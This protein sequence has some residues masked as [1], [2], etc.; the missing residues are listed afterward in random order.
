MTPEQRYKTRQTKPR[1]RH[2]AKNS[3]RL[4]QAMREHQAGNLAEADRLYGSVLKKNPDDA[5]ALNLRGIL[6]AQ[7][8]RPA[9]GIDYISR[10]LRIDD[11][12]PFYHYNLALVYQA[13][14]NREAAIAS[15]R[16]ALSL[17]SDYVD[18]LVNLGNLLFNKGENAEA[19]ACY[20]KATRLAPGNAMAHNNLGAALL[21]Q[22]T[23]NEAAIC[24]REALRL[25]P[26]YA[27]AHNGLGATFLGLELY[28]E[29]EVSLKAALRHD[30]G[31][32]RAHNNLGMTYACKG[33]FEDAIASFRAA[34][35]FNPA[36][37]E[38]HLNL[39]RIN[40][41]LD[42]LDAAEASYREA[43]RL[44]P[45]D[46]KARLCLGK[47][48]EE[49]EDFDTALKVF[50]EIL[51]KNPNH[52]LALTG[53]ASVL[54]RAGR[55]A[56]ANAI[57]RG[58]VDAGTLPPEAA[59]I[60]AGLADTLSGASKSETSRSEVA[61]RLENA[62]EGSFLNSE[63]RRAIHFALGKLYDQLGAYDRAFPHFAEGNSLR[64]TPF[65]LAA[66]EAN[67][68]QDIS[69]F[70]RE[71]LAQL[72]RATNRSEVPVFVV[73][74]PRSGTSLVEQILDCHPDVFGAGELRDIGEIA[75]S[76]KAAG[77]SGG[78]RAEFIHDV[79]Q[80]AIDMAAQRH[81]ERLHELA[82]DA[83]R[84][85]DKMPYNFLHL[86]FISLLFP[87]ARVIHCVRDPLDTCLSCYFQNFRSG[88][89][90]SFDLQNVGGFYVQYQRLMRH[91]QDVLD[92]P[93]LEVRY[94]EHVAEPE[95]V[96]REMLDFLGLDW[97]SRCLEFHESKRVVR[98][99]SRE[100]VR[101]PIYTRSAGRWRNYERHLGPLKEALSEIL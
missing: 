16:R 71:R 88:N 80:V 44:K 31:H 75:T 45:D 89:F 70:T 14:G 58:L 56:E 10:A 17:K 96:C 86:G 54:L 93:I 92:I 40:F 50:G 12:N 48:F 100:Q 101:E 38:G 82:G 79:N 76:L 63:G 61:N 94:E 47:V 5:E 78:P 39:G 33:R 2:G 18:A 59:E 28:S 91:W 21:A 3:A 69:F 19:V 42:R 26:D 34:L 67:A 72:P 81:L 7:A 36:Y 84:V 52:V 30:P 83:K 60:F 9:V 11:G 35:R 77:N 68:K 6:V 1:N 20:R 57:M 23:W 51:G 27:D 62:L 99:A 37:A 46:L 8:G 29:A 66:V 90:H 53:K 49:R 64:P 41:E 97:D 43:L 65:S 15:Y 95:K 22:E 55:V 4:E 85:T 73:G 13:A 24:F 98:T 87:G 32:A 25:R 74:M